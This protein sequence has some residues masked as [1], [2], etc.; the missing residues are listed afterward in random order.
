MLSIYLIEAR[1]AIFQVVISVVRLP[2]FL[3]DLV[4][5]YRILPFVNFAFMLIFDF[6]LTRR[7][8]SHSVTMILT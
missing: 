8:V 5:M 2:L 4:C 3:R 7:D 6:F 1:D